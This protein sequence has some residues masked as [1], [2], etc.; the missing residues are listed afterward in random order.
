M[1]F[2]LKIIGVLVAGAGGVM[3]LIYGVLSRMDCGDEMSGGMSDGFFGAAFVGASVYCLAR[4]GHW[5]SMVY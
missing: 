1:I 5:L 4:W 2:V 3:G